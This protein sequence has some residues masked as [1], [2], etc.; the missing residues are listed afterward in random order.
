MQLGLQSIKPVRMGLSDAARKRS[1][2]GYS[3][4]VTR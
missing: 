1:R 4:P 3:Q 2:L